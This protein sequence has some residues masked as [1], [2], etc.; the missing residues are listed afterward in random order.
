MQRAIVPILVV[1]LLGLS[2]CPERPGVKK[3]AKPAA[4][5]GKSDKGEKAGKD[6]KKP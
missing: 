3:D 6:A 1:S 5:E 2:G 4:K